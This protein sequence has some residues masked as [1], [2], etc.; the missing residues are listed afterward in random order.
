M[1]IDSPV[2]L[3]ART[4]INDFVREIQQGK[5][6]P[7]KCPWK[8]LKTCEYK[9]VQFCIAEALFNAAKGN[10]TKG[11]SFAGEKAYLAKK[12]MSVRET[13]NEIKAEYFLEELKLKPIKV[14]SCC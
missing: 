12:I 3:P 2:G 13:V 6:K 1:I 10:F 11:F 7:V 8:C 5:K 14:L 4:I 9:K